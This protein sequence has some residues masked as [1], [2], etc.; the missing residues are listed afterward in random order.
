MEDYDYPFDKIG[1][2]SEVYPLLMFISSS[3]LSN[4]NINLEESIA[5]RT[6]FAKRGI[7]I[8]QKAGVDPLLVTL[9]PQNTI[10][11]IPP[12][13]PLYPI[14]ISP[15]EDPSYPGDPNYAPSTTDD[16]DVLYDIS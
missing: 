13:I 16:S 1:D 5:Q 2:E 14:T 10:I 9:E 4:L 3:T 8:I 7:H 12:I 15:S 6:P 11:D